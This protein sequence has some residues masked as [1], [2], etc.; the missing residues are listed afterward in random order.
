[1]DHVRSLVACLLV[2]HERRVGTGLGD[3]IL[4]LYDD[5]QP[6]TGHK[7]SGGGPDL[8]FDGDALSGTQECLAR[9]RMHRLL[10]GRAFFVQLTVTHSQ[11][12]QRRGAILQES[13]ENKR[14]LA[15]VDIQLLDR[16]EQVHV[17]RADRLDPQAQLHVTGELRVAAENMIEL[18]APT[19]VGGVVPDLAGSSYRRLHPT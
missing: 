4:S 13:I 6:L 10:R 7:V 1:M 8:D 17:L 15:A 11:P 18:H 2:A 19:V 9:M 5:S 12:T 16:D 14:P 3:D